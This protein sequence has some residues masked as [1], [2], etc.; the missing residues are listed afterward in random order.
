MKKLNLA[1]EKYRT[2]PKSQKKDSVHIQE[3]STIPPKPRK[4]DKKR[5]FTIC[6]LVAQPP[7]TA[8]FLFQNFGF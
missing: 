2:W 6:H 4:R 7:P 5:K 1:Q 8:F 3:S